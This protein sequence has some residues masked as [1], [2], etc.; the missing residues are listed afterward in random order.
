MADVENQLLEWLRE[1]S[2]DA[3]DIVDLPWEVKMV[4]EGTYLAEHPKMP[5][6]L[7]VYFTPEFVVLEAP[8][9]LAVDELPEEVR[10]LVYRTLLEL[11][12]AVYM[13]KF[14]LTDPNGTVAIRVDLDKKTLGKAE[15]NDALTSMLFGLL[16]GVMSLGVEEEF[17]Q[18]FVNR[19]LESLQE[20]VRKGYTYDQLLE[21]MTVRVGVSEEDAKKIVDELLRSMSDEF[22]RS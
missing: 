13:M 8:T 6:K 17:I 18:N 15:F 2:E 12:D 22:E 3:V 1:G 5:F 11:N 19:I 21:F 9:N 16:I 4:S 14:A 20:K 10:P 7:L